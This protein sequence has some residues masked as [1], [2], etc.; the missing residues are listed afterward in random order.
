MARRLWGSWK[1]VLHFDF[2]HYYAEISG[3]KDEASGETWHL[4]GS[5]SLASKYLPADTVNSN[6]PKF[7]YRSLY[8][9]SQGDFAYAA[10]TLGTF[11]QNIDSGFSCGIF[12]FPLG[13]SEGGII[14]FM[15]GESSVLALTLTSDRKLKASCPAWSLDTAS[16]NALT[17]NAW[18]YVFMAVKKSSLAVYADGAQVISSSAPSSSLNVT[19]LRIGGC[20]AMFDEFS[21][22]GY[23]SAY[24]VPS[25]PLQASLDMTLMGGFGTGQDGAFS[26]SSSAGFS[27]NT[28][29]NVES[30]SGLTIRVPTRSNASAFSKEISAGDEIM[31]HVRQKGAS[32]AYALAGLYDFARVADASGGYITL[33]KNITAFDM[34]EA[35]RDYTLAACKVP[36][37]SS[38]NITAGW[39]RPQKNIIVFRCTGNVYWGGGTYFSPQKRYDPL[40]VTHSDLPDRMIDSG[41]NFL[42]FCGGTFTAPASGRLGARTSDKVYRP[43]GYG[44]GGG[45]EGRIMTGTK[46]S[47]YYGANLLI[48]AKKLAVDSN[49]LQYGAKNSSAFSGLCYMAG[50]LS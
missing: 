30:V 48:A 42:A 29:G 17:Q 21:Y 27:I 18:H 22:G 45:N 38:V 16:A 40:A 19:A 50:D 32:G 37:F 12:V 20:P 15:N 31:L 33:E 39:M 36:N 47:G 49:A 35:V 14:Q 24:A 4:S 23:S 1:S 8:T 5:A 11:T 2:P 28:A 10:N 43:N 44:G 34:A 41:L 25:Q 9:S 46:G 3:L 6:A 13:A 26:W 7:G